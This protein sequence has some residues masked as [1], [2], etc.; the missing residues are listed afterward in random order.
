MES[1]PSVVLDLTLPQIGGRGGGAEP[2][3]LSARSSTTRRC[4]RRSQTSSTG[5]TSVRTIRIA[6]EEIIGG[7]GLGGEPFALERHDVYKARVLPRHATVHG[8]REPMYTANTGLA[9]DVV[10]ARARVVMSAVLDRVAAIGTRG[11][12]DFRRYCGQAGFITRCGQC[13][14]SYFCE[15]CHPL[16]WRYH[17]NWC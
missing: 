16:A 11:A 6:D 8:W 14:V 3:A 2:F 4:L 17:K 15:P 13:K 9:S 5:T 7:R 12:G 10:W 1:D